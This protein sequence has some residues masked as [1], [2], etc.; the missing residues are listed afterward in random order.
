VPASVANERGDNTEVETLDRLCRYF[1]CRIE[2]L[3]E[4]EATTILMRGPS[5]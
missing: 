5:T 1:A 2:Q 3:V 4:Y